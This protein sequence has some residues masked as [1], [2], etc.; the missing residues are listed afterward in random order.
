[1]HDQNREIEADQELVTKRERQKRMQPELLRDDAVVLLGISSS[2]MMQDER[3]NSM[4]ASTFSC[5]ESPEVVQ[6]LG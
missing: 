2:G 3:S 5:G 1:L 4:K 6:P